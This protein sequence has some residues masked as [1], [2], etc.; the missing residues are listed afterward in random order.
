L[1]SSE[2]ASSWTAA[3][4]ATIVGTIVGTVQYMAPEQAKGQPVDGR[5]DQYSLGVVGYRMVTG[6]LPFSGDSVHTILYKH[7][8]EEA[9]QV[10][11]IRA[12][13]PDFLSQSIA[14]AMAKE[15]AQRYAT[16]EELATALWP[17]QPVTP[18]GIKTP[19]IQ[20]PRPAVTAESPTEAFASAAGAATT[21]L[22]S[23]APAPASRPGP[24]PPLVAAP[25]KKKSSAGLVIGLLVVAGSGVGGYLALRPKTAPSPAPVVTA[26]APTPPSRPLVRDVRLQPPQATLRPAGTVA[27][28]ATPVDSTGIAVAGQ[29]VEWTSSD[30]RV[31]RVDGQGRVTAVG[32]GLAM[33][34]AKV[35]DVRGEAAV[36]VQAPQQ[37]ATVPQQRPPPQA[38]AVEEGYLSIDAVPYGTVFVDNVD[39]GPTPIS[40]YPV[41]PGQHTIRIENPGFRTHTERVNVDAGNTVRKRIPLVPEGSH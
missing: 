16:M 34:A 2:V 27:F 4:A 1:P 10:Q 15:P 11:S 21:P 20:R 3:R 35:G 23:A 8:F 26:P 18:R 25:A 7:I 29:R 22:P 41:K 30:P 28:N 9:P 37:T 17:E 12:D 40:R 14:R 32:A 6:Q 19:S 33:I 39:I 31:A 24:R 5:A 13:V 38:P 36:Q